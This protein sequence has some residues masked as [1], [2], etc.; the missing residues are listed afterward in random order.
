MSYSTN[1]LLPKARATALRLLIA[2][3][4][5]LGVVADR[6]GVHRTTLWRWKRKWECLNKHVGQERMNRPARQTNF[7]PAYYKWRI[8]TKSSR[9]HSHPRAI[10]EC[11]VRRVLAL[12]E[13]L[14]RCAEVVWHHLTHTLGIYIS[15]S[16]VK[17]IF[18]RHHVYERATKRRRSYHRSLP[19]PYVAKPGESRLTL[20]T[21]STRLP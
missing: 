17:R 21:W 3:R 10:P 5:P 18:R 7:Q 4:I 14:R 8:V 20:F 13:E 19:R 12:R 16:S 1:P 2:E 11:I 6:C 9:P 15:L